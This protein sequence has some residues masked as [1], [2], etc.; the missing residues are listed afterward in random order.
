MTLQT[1]ELS[2]AINTI[3]KCFTKK[4][5]YIVNKVDQLTKACECVCKATVC[6]EKMSP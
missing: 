1:S 6:P 5:M 4:K 3:T 2:P